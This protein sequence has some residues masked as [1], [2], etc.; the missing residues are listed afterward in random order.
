MSKKLLNIVNF[1]R[2]CEPR[3]EV[4][5]Y[6]PVEEQISLLSRY[7]FKGTFLLQYDAMEDER[8]LSLMKSDENRQNELGVWFEVVEGLCKAAEIPWRGRFPWDWHANVGFS[9]G[10]TLDERERLIDCLFEKFKELFGYYPS[11]IGSWI[12]DAHSL[13]YASRKYGLDAS[14]NCKDQWG[15]DGYT[16]WGAYYNGAY[17]PSKNNA[18]APASTAASGIDVPVFRML[19][20]DPVY[21]YD[22]GLDP[23]LGS[24]SCQG[25]ITLEPVYS[26]ENGGGGEEKWVDWFLSSI[27]NGK[28][29]AYAYT[30]AGQENSF[31]WEAMRDGLLMQFERFAALEREGLSIETLG[32]SGRW[33]K[34]SFDV[35]PSTSIVSLSD[36]KDSSKS[37]VWYNSRF[38][39][40]NLYCDEDDGFRIRDLVLFDDNYFE[41]YFDEICK[42]SVLKYDNLSFIDGNRFSGGG[43]RAGG[44]FCFDGEENSRLEKIT[45]EEKG[46]SLLVSVKLG[47]KTLEILCE[48]ERII[49]STSSEEDFSLLIR[50]DPS[51][52]VALSVTEGGMV[53]NHCGFARTLRASVSPAF[54]NSGEIVFSSNC[55][56]LV[57]DT[58][59]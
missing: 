40:L 12:I 15:T 21:Q 31:G 23:S 14:C 7:G 54:S 5:L 43:V 17:Y 49:F 1:I 53:L 55:G 26:G 8:F 39:R 25:V 48:E 59:R 33:F 9:V 13:A 2:G 3:C 24:S 36:W 45:V 30:Q 37:S 6:R 35:T 57:F 11:V 18:F 16:L 10:Y 32:E 56:R 27:Y 47:K 50:F 29:L 44:Y 38:Y 58:A 28:S 19:G 52:E 46:S 34:K 22:M 20:S 42:S 4:D 41:R 51:K